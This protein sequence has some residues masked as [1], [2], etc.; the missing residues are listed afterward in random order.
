[1]LSFHSENKYVALKSVFYPGQHVGILENGEL[2]PPS[3]TTAQDRS[4]LF[5]PYPQPMATVSVVIMQGNFMAKY[6]TGE[7][8]LP[9]TFTYTHSQLRNALQTPTHPPPQQKILAFP[10]PPLVHHKYK[11]KVS[12]WVRSEANSCEY[13]LCSYHTS[14]MTHWCAEEQAQAQ[15]GS[16]QN[17]ESS[18]FDSEKDTSRGFLQFSDT[19]KLMNINAIHY[20]EH[21]I[22]I[23]I[24]PIKLQGWLTQSS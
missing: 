22:F 16:L 5:I 15:K 7:E 3:E 12:I 20:I 8:G 9:S 21:Y 24:T 19:F 6:D 13:C 2:K 11:L 1:M 17:A 23:H 18:E 4:S 10:L 14:A